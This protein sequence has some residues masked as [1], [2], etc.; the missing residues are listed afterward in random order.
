M[1]DQAIQ[2]NLYSQA[3]YCVEIF[4]NE[5]SLSTGTCFFVKREDRTF[6]VTNWHIVSGCNA[7][8]KEI[9]NQYGAIPNI[10]RIFV[11]R[12]NGDGSA[13]YDDAS[14]IDINLYN[15]DNE[16][17]WYEKSVDERMIDVALIPIDNPDFCHITI[18]QAEKPFNEN[19]NIE[20]ASEIYIIGFPFAKQT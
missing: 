5:M 1:K 13:Q 12:D 4:F 2:I 14:Y 11:P 16:P 18:E 15:E 3:S 7:D 19:V 20:I 6:L 9:L 8:T 10:L 17:L